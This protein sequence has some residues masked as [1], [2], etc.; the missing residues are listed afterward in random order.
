MNIK[1][2][3]RRQMLASSA[4]GAAMLLNLRHCFASEPMAQ[5]PLADTLYIASNEYP[6]SVFYARENRNFRDEL[7]SS[8]A[9][10]KAAGLVGFEPSVS[11]A[12]E[13]VIL[14]DAC[15][16][17][18]LKMRSV[19]TSSSFL[20]PQDV[21]HSVDR[22]TAMAKAA[23]DR[24]GTE[25]VITNPDPIGRGKTDEELSAQA[26]G[27]CALGESL[28][29]YG[30]RLGYHHHAPEM[31]F[32]A[33]EVHHMLA[34]TDQKYVGFCFDTHWVYRGAGN[35]AVAVYDFLTLYGDRMV[36]F[37]LRQS[38][39]DIW[40]EF[41]T[42]NDDLD[43]HRIADWFRTKKHAYPMLVSEQCPESATPHTMNALQ[44]HQR[45]VECIRRVFG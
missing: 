15:E 10:V 43:F 29:A 23:H 42:E 40:S 12:E 16:K 30:I 20:M 13:A 45:D 14:A 36:S 21:Q 41:L 24:I 11:T 17:A 7:A 39:N 37:H 32:G 33:R 18:C 28:A 44:A 9:E 8:L 1:K 4:F 34:G 31:E 35:S 22:I 3:Q 26:E 25:L 2:T 6:W 19:Y 27:L 5:K 38:V